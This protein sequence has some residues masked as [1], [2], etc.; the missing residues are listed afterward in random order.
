MSL[1]LQ[2]PEA[3]HENKSQSYHYWYTNYKNRVNQQYEAEG[4]YINSYMILHFLETQLR[5]PVVSPVPLGAG[6]VP[7]S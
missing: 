3:R 2:F 4:L 6:D 7:W 1:I 5:Y